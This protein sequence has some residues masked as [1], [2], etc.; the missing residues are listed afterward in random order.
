MLLINGLQRVSFVCLCLQAHLSK[1]VSIADLNSF[2]GAN[3]ALHLQMNSQHINS[4]IAVWQNRAMGTFSPSRRAQLI[5]KE[6][7]GLAQAQSGAFGGLKSRFDSDLASLQT[8]LWCVLG[9]SCGS[10]KGGAES[11]AGPS[12]VQGHWGVQDG[13]GKSEDLSALPL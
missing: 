9:E 3:S 2:L 6:S 13:G 12:C 10:T 5:W 4:K 1:N 7:S 8:Q 11:T